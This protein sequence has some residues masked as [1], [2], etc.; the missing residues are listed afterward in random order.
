FSRDW[1]SDVCSSDLIAPGGSCTLTYRYRPLTADTTQNYLLTFV[2]RSAQREYFMQNMKVT[3][4]PRSPGKLIA[5]EKNI[6]TINYKPS[7]SEERRV[8]KERNT[9]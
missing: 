9:R 2:Y 7:R 4:T 8:G 5:L 3:L 1:S 6:Q